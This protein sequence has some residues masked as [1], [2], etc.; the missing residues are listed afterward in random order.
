MHRWAY[1]IT[2]AQVALETA[3]VMAG[4]VVIGVVGLIL[5][6]AIALLRR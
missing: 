3:K 6:Q 2:T 5:S 1:L 4:I